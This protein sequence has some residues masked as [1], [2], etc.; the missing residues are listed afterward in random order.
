[1]KGNEMES[2]QIAGKI[3]RRDAS[4][5]AKER[6]ETGVPV[7]DGLDM[8]FPANAFA[9]RRVE[10]LVADTHGG[11]TRRIAGTAVGHPQ[12]IL[13]HDRR[14]DISQGLGV[15]RRQDGADGRAGTVRRDQNRHLFIIVSTGPS[16]QRPGSPVRRSMQRTH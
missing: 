4:T 16:H 15:D 7:V 5:A 8:Q 1:M 13:V 14:K 12:R 9:G 3:F 2:P 6:L 10:R 11:G